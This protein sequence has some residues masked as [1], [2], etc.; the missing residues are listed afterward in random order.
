MLKNKEDFILGINHRKINNRASTY[1]QIIR[2][3]RLRRHMTLED[4]SKDICSVSY[5]CKLENSVIKTNE[6]FVRSLCER[7]NL[8][9]D[10]IST[11]EIEN[12]VEEVV[13]LVFLKKD[14]EVEDLY[15]K[16]L[17]IP[18]N[19]GTQIVKC[20]YYL[21]KNKF[22]DFEEEVKLLDNIKYTLTDVESIALLY[23]IILYNMN[24]HNYLEAYNYLKLI[25]LIKINN[26]YL[27]YLILEAN[28]LVSYNINNYCRLIN[29]YMEYDKYD[30]VGYPL[31][32]KIISKMI[33]NVFMSDEFPNE[34]LD[35]VNAL[36]LSIIPIDS[37]LDVIYYIMIIRMKNGQ[38]TNIFREI[39]DKN[40]C[41]DA[42]FMGLLAYI[43]YNVNKKSLYKELLSITENYVFDDVDTIHQKFVYFILLYSTTK[44]KDDI[45]KY[46]KDQINPYLDIEINPLYN[47]IYKK[48]YLEHL[49]ST[50]KYKESYYFLS[51][52]MNY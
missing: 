5:L 44:N 2:N 28:I 7:F 27:N 43:C 46:M 17:N 19:S 11:V 14:G 32:R 22:K 16:N 3:E 42:R 24:K 6:T 36:D 21:Q 10:S 41:Y 52:H 51:Q 18:F 31:G 45:V 26:K 40:Y 4:A 34:V 30:M 9:Y 33:N 15:Q 48:I 47:K 50:S 49:L 20:F 1:A 13:K 23:L 12:L 25:D 38:L 35:D 39:I 37:K 8:N 29:S